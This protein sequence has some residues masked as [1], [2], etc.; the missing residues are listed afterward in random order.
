MCLSLFLKH[1]FEF[2]YYVHELKTEMSLRIDDYFGKTGFSFQKLESGG[3]YLGVSGGC[4]IIVGPSN[5]DGNEDTAFAEKF[6]GRDYIFAYLYKGEIMFKPPYLRAQFEH[7]LEM[8]KVA[9]GRKPAVN[10][11]LHL[12]ISRSCQAT[13]FSPLKADWASR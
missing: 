9:I 7:Y 8:L 12:A 13:D 10:L 1:E 11:L 5:R 3:E 6:G 4:L 2:D